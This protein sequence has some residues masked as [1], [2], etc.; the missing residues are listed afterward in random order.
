MKFRNFHARTDAKCL[1]EDRQILDLAVGPFKEYSRFPQMVL[2]QPTPLTI[3]L[4][5]ALKSRESAQTFN[6]DAELSIATLSTILDAGA[7]LISSD[8]STRRH[9]P[10]GGALYPLE[11]YVFPYRVE[12]LQKHC[13]HY[14]PRTHVLEELISCPPLPNLSDI[15]YEPPP[16]TS[17]AAIILITSLWNRNFPKYGEFAYRLSLFEAGHSVQNMLLAATALSVKARPVGGIE[18]EKVVRL[19][20]LGQS[21]EDPLYLLALSQ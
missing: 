17:P 2:P 18:T 12:S 10:S 1:L 3:G 7:G 16:N 4:T 5:D 20:D 11:Y 14:A 15:W 9:H 13:Y 6:T 21:T 19:L 8:G